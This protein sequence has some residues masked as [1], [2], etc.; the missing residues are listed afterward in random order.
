MQSRSIW[1][2]LKCMFFWLCIPAHW[3]WNETINMASQLFLISQVHSITSLIRFCIRKLSVSSH[4]C[5]LL[6]DF[7]VT[8]NSF[9][10]SYH[11]LHYQWRQVNQHLCYT[12][13]NYNTRTTLFH[14]GGW[15]DALVLGQ[16]F[17]ASMPRSCHHFDTSQYWSYLSTIPF[18][19]TLQNSATLICPQ[20]LFQELLG[21]I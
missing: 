11:Q 3:I 5:R 17:L 14:R 9:C 12:S 20:Y 2:V 16:F 8:Q 18:P 10:C 19:R 7:G 4:D 6:I 13:Q 21:T 1:T 15:G